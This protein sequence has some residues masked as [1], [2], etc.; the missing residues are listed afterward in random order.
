MLALS[1]NNVVSGVETAY[2]MLL[3]AVAIV[4]GLW[5]GNPFVPSRR[6]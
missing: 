5:F 3:V 1:A 6:Q 4:A 2:E